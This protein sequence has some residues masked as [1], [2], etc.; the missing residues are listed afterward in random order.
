MYPSSDIAFQSYKGLE[1]HE[2]Y[3]NKLD[4]ELSFKKTETDLPGLQIIRECIKSRK[5][6]PSV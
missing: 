5:K 4:L 2:I 1:N 3:Q 6:K